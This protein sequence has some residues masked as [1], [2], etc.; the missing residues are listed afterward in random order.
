[1]NALG[2]EY[3]RV[4]LQ[5]R[6]LKLSLRWIMLFRAHRDGCE[7]DQTDF[8]TCGLKEAADSARAA[9]TDKETT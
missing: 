4:A 7:V 1:M 8:C 3:S 5:N 6:E 2:E 9:L